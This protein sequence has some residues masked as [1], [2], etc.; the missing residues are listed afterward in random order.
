M[1]RKHMNVRFTNLSLGYERYQLYLLHFINA[2]KY[3][4]ELRAAA[5]EQWERIVHHKFA[6][7]LASGTIDRRVLRRY[8]IQD[9]RFLDSFVILLASVIAHCRSLADRIPACQFLALI[10]S[11]ES[12]YFERCFEALN[13]CDPSTR[14]AIADAPCTT[15]FCNLMCD[16]AMNGSLG[17]ML[18]VL[19]VCEWSYLSWGQ[20]VQESTVRDDFCTYEW[21]DLHSGPHFEQ[22]VAYLRGLLDQEGPQMTKDEKDKCQQRFLQAVQLEEDFFE[23]AYSAD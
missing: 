5:G 23:Y 14:A 19:V 10:T 12:T 13:D 8:L 18:S 7:E 21:V 17:E 6:A 1:L 15:G 11:K 4:E 9:Y 22:V 2:M 16:V 20:R 3:T